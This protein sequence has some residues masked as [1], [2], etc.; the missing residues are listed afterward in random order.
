MANLAIFAI[1]A[2]SVYRGRSSWFVTLW[3]PLTRG[4]NG[5]WA[6]VVYVVLVS[7]LIGW[8]AKPRS[9]AGT[10][11]GTSAG[12]VAIWCWTLTIAHVIGVTSLWL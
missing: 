5:S 11:A 10:T 3:L 2:M 6:A 7:S 8:A 12:R 9:L 1:F 4:P